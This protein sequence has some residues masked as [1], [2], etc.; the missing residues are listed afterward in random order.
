MI[1]GIERVAKATLQKMF[2]D[3]ASGKE[4]VAE[5][6]NDPVHRKYISD[7]VHGYV[8]KD[9]PKHDK[10]VDHL[11]NAKNFGEKTVDSLSDHAG[12][13]YGTAKAIS[14]EVS[15]DLKAN[16]GAPSKPQ[17]QAQRVGAYLKQKQIGPRSK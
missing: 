6:Y 2:R 10:I 1:R 4:E 11:H 16:F 5:G 14:K 13:S 8:S 17:T 12:I 3:K 7:T 9:D 15:S